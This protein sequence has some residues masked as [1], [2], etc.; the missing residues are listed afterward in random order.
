M[1]NLSW[2]GER[3]QKY[4]HTKLSNNMD[5]SVEINFATGEF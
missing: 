1:T 4:A 5:N 3:E 2:T